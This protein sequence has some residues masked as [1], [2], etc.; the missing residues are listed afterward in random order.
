MTIGPNRVACA[1]CDLPIDSGD[2]YFREDSRWFFHK[3]CLGRPD[4]KA[5]RARVYVLRAKFN[6]Y[7]VGDRPMSPPARL[8]RELFDAEAALARSIT[9]DDRTPSIGPDVEAEEHK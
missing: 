9:D 3:G 2:E 4:R 5:L 7:N 8:I 1:G 6:S